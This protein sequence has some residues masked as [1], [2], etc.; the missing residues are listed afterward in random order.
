[1]NGVAR[2]AV[3]TLAVL[4]VMAPVVGLLN[5]WFA[6]DRWPLKKLRISGEFSQ[7]SDQAL[8]DAVKEDADIGFF[9]VDLDRLRE[10]VEALP[11]VARAEVRKQ[12]PDTLMI[13]V[14]ERKAVARWG[15][16][17]LLSADGEIFVAPQTALSADLPLLDGPESRIDD[18][19]ELYRRAGQLMA[20]SGQQVVGVSLDARASWRLR[21]A[22]GGNVIIGRGD[23]Q[24]RDQRLR[25]FARAVPALVANES[26]RLARAD[27]RYSTGF[28]IHWAQPPASESDATPEAAD[29]KLSAAALTNHKSRIT[30]HGSNT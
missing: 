15:D 3:W 26:R 23:N 9:A 29:D 18:V 30:N 22:G 4:L 21:L 20:P 12:W 27:L 6:A 16:D 28:A 5:G 7:V 14:F 24:Q 17:R 1:M 8:R 25:R 11:W 2:F 10:R 19:V 13:R